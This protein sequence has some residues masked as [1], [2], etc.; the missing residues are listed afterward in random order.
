MFSEN[1]P[2]NVWALNLPHDNGWNAALEATTDNASLSSG[3]SEK[4]YIFLCLPH[5]RLGHRYAFRYFIHS[6]V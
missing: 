4:Y 3:K 2:I 5:G 6:I 1:L